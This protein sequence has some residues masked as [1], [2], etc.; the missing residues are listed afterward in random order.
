MNSIS[1][2]VLHETIRAFDDEIT[3][4]VTYLRQYVCNNNK[5]HYTC[6]LSIATSEELLLL[7]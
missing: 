1:H 6:E 3:T 4:K 5:L 2:M 7:P